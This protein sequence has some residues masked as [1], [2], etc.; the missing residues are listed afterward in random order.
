MKYP[1]LVV[2]LFVLFSV[3]VTAQITE[4]TYVGLDFYIG[5]DVGGVANGWDAHMVMGATAGFYLSPRKNIEI[6]NMDIGSYLLFCENKGINILPLLRG[7][8]YNNIVTTAYLEKAGRF[9]IGIQSG[10][11]SAGTYVSEL[12]PDAPL[13]REHSVFKS[14]NYIPVLLSFQHF[15]SE[16]AYH[17]LKTVITTKAGKEIISDWFSKSYI[18]GYRVSAGP[19]FLLSGFD[20]RSSLPF[21]INSRV[22]ILL[23]TMGRHFSL[24]TNIYYNM[25]I[26]GESDFMDKNYMGTLGISLTLSL[27]T[28]GHK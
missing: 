2:L 14:M 7:Q 25:L 10:Y 28:R 11:Q 1:L 18:W 8:D 19:A 16:P 24:N 17:H 20:P 27:L 6:N 4:S 15:F 5:A 13:N 9:G 22:E 21:P 26:F 23:G 12:D 3:P